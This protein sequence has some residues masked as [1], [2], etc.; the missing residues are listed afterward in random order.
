MNAPPCSA[1]EAV[2][3]FLERRRGGEHLDPAAFAAR[4]PELGPDLQSA[5]EAL[6]AL[7]R[8]ARPEEPHGV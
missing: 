8:A 6:V 3:L 2:E 1:G 7:E 5:L 4:Y